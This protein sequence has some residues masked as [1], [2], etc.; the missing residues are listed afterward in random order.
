MMEQCC[1]NA[2]QSGTVLDQCGTVQDGVEQCWNSRGP[3]QFTVEQCQQSH[4]TYIL[5]HDGTV[6]QQC[7]SEWNSS[8]S[9]RNSA[10]RCG[11]VL[12][13]SR[14]SSIHCGTVST[15]SF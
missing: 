9:V 2:T 13:Q 8:G 12:E 11:T 14:T 1:N 3:V 6:L 7:N 10:R 15:E 4:S 5:I